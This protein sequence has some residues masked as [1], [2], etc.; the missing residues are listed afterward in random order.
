MG[1]NAN[2]QWCVGS[3]KVTLVWI[4]HKVRPKN[5]GF[6][7]CEV[8]SSRQVKPKFHCKFKLIW[9]LSCSCGLVPQKAWIILGLFSR[10]T[11]HDSLF[12]DRQNASQHGR[13]RVG[14]WFSRTKLHS[15]IQ[16]DTSLSALWARSYNCHCNVQT[17]LSVQQHLPQSCNH[18]WNWRN[19]QCW[20]HIFSQVAAWQFHFQQNFNHLKGD[21][22]AFSTTGSRR[23]IRNN[24]SGNE[25]AVLTRMKDAPSV[26]KMTLKVAGAFKNF[27]MFHWKEPKTIISS[28]TW[29]SRTNNVIRVSKIFPNLATDVHL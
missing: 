8:S 15:L 6:L 1:L 3:N 24:H 23:G 2:A 21:Q 14:A 7:I 9:S 13:K 10:T 5:F 18:V 19:Y 11:P 12:P 4:D 16:S 17:C 27:Q 26:P 29:P 22:R 25:N 20:I 28:V